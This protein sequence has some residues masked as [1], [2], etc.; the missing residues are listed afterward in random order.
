[1]LSHPF[2]TIPLLRAL[3]PYL[4]GIILTLA[5]PNFFPVLPFSLIGFTILGALMLANRLSVRLYNLAWLPGL[6]VLIGF[7]LF[8]VSRVQ[9]VNEQDHPQHFEHK[10]QEGALVA[11]K[12]TEPPKP[13]D[14]TLKLYGEALWLWNDGNWNEAK[15]RLLA[16][17]S[18]DSIARSLDYGDVII[19]QNEFD[20][21]EP[22]ANPKQFNRKAFLANK[23]IYHQAFLD[24]NQWRKTGLNKGKLFFRWIY[25][26]RHKC[27]AWLANDITD[28]D[29]FAVAAALIAGYKA[30]IDPDL[31][32]SYASTGAMHVLAV[33]GLHVGI[34]YLMLNYALS[35]LNPLRFGFL[36]K[37]VIIISLL[38]IY[39]C[40]TGLPSSVIRACTMFSFVAIGT[41]LNRTTNIYGSITASLL[42]L[43][44][45]NP[46]L[47]TQVGFQLSYAAVIGIIFLQPRVYNLFPQSRFWLV[48]KIWA[49]TAVSIAAQISTF[50]LTLFYFNQFPTYFMISNLVVIP[51]AML[52]VPTGFVFLLMKGMGLSVVS[53][54]IGDALDTILQTLNFSISKVEALPYSLIDQ[55][56]ITTP[57]F[58]LIYL[59]IIGLSTGIVF[60]HKAL[61][62][63][64]LSAAVMVLGIINYD[65]WQKRNLKQLAYLKV[66]NATVI[67]GIGAQEAL[68]KGPKAVL[69]VQDQVKFFTYRF[70][71]SQGLQKE[72]IQKAYIP[73]RKQEKEGNAYDTL[74][75]EH[76]V[77]IQDHKVLV[78]S[79]PLYWPDTSTCQLSVDHLLVTHD[80]A[81]KPQHAIQHLQV[82]RVILGFE[83]APWTVQEWNYV[84]RKAPF[85]CHV[86]SEDGA[87]I[88]NL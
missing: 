12:L 25:D 24:T 39:A 52:I 84:S 9:E 88:K 46:Y 77:S 78:A 27:L 67:A 19:C 37:V 53:G 28:E 18:K 70:L 75:A 15:G 22:P 72:A 69:N 68:L 33:S 76:F 3:I 35:F 26:I 30:E 2:K 48:D 59:I 87:F 54:Y 20:R 14:K 51:A 21:L 64:G 50:P 11:L 47:L 82:D 80:K 17:I 58:Y 79:E 74:N 73:R 1:M 83:L 66:D 81:L 16:Y 40:V 23:Q 6:I 4:I 60:R 34:I 42:L 49:I 29:A 13:S 31:R 57:S 71:W 63:T 86:L 5:F 32:S 45:I 38:W 8:G 44:L 36:S 62:F 10:A 61:L 55:L 43:L 41:N 56:Y 7:L 65:T 85:S